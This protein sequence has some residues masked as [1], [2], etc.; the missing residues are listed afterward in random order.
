MGRLRQ[1]LDS[2]SKTNPSEW[3]VV[4]FS[5]LRLYALPTSALLGITGER[6]HARDVKETLERA[7]RAPPIGLDGW[8][9]EI[10]TAE[11]GKLAWFPAELIP[12]PDNPYDANAVAVFSP[13]GHVGYLDRDHALA[14]K[15]TFDMLANNGYAG[16][17]VPAFG[18]LEEQQVV[19]C[20]SLAENCRRHLYHEFVCPRAWQAL[21][22]GENPE[23]VAKRFGY[24]GTGP[25]RRA[26]RS[27]ARDSGLPDPEAQE[28][29]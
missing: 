5:T 9:S 16:A 28:I 15:Q 7:G 13:Y 23:H 14:Y 22:L 24:T 20:L 12:Q 18:R 17:F 4:P 1:L 19:L 29:R 3:E 2:A 10:A 25:L 6:H 8:A 27:W 21:H 11:R 26:V